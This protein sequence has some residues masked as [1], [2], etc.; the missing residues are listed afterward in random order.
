MYSRRVFIKQHSLAGLGLVIGS[1]AFS[2]QPEY[3]DDIQ[4]I[5]PVEGDTLH[6]HDGVMTDAFLT[7]QVRITAH[8][9]SLITINNIPAKKSKGIFTA[10]I[11]LEHYKNSIE[12]VNKKTGVKKNITVYWFKNL[13]DKYRLS[14][15]D[16]IWFLKDIHT[17]TAAYNSIFENPFLEFLKQVH[18]THGTKVHINIFY[19]T[20][21]FNLSQMTDKFKNEW[22]ENAGWLQM[23][24]HANAEF[25]DD[26]YKY[27][28]YA[29]V[30]KECS[31]VIE[32]I[33]RFAGDELASSI[34]TLHWGEV[35]VEVSRALRDCGYTGQL[36]DF[37]VDDHLSPCSYYLD[38]EQ[39]RHMKK[40]FVWRDNKEDITFI[41]SS[42]IIDTKKLPEVIPYLDQYEK[43][44][45]KPPYVDLLVHEQYFYDYYHNYQP[46]YRTKV[47]TAV[48]WAVDKG[49]TP[50]FLS[51]CIYE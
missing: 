2:E 49:Y 13:A 12:V 1:S 14:I 23:S 24:F 5:S 32:Q 42:I 31:A 9:N 16:A 44:S 15:D 8:D 29:Q 21:G 27:A 50:A 4:F 39:R 36:C 40:R 11:N 26:P 28:G 25:P 38:V 34:T 18:D 37:N 48:K 46:D 45:R 35:P 19:E 6:K 51:E 17:N 3:A 33:R 22:R 30:K 20:D 7:T 43:E 41:K 47:L 10:E